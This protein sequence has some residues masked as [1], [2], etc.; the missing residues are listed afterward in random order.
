RFTGLPLATGTLPANTTSKSCVKAAD[1]DRDGD[2]DLFIGGRVIPDQYPKATSSLLLR[3]DSKPGQP[4]FTDVTAQV[5]PA[6]NNIGLVCDALWTDPDNDG[7]VD[8]ML[9]GEFMPLTL[10]TNDGGKLTNQ[11]TDRGLAKSVGWWNSLVAGD[12]DRD[13]DIDYIAGN[14]GLNARMRATNEEPVRMYAGDFDNNGFYDAIP[15]IF[16]PDADGRRQEYT[17]HGR[18]DLIKQMIVMR[19]RFPYYKDFA[20]ATIDK[21]LT[22]EERQNAT[23]LEANYLQSAYVENK[24]DGTFAIRALPVQAQLAPIFGMV[25]EDVDRDG[26]LDVV[27]VGNDFSGEVLSGRY[28]ALNGLWLRGNGKGNFTAQSIA[29]SGFYVP[30]NGKAL[31]QLTDNKGAE[32][33]VATQNRGRL[34]IFRNSKPVRGLRLSPTDATALLTFSDGKKQKV[35]FSYGNSFLSQS[36]RRLLVSPQVKSVE[37]TDSQGRKRQGFQPNTLAKK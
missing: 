26:N 33:L 14:L 12:F 35:E 27:L 7:D 16:I 20:G 23:V 25:A 2:L 30:G 32:L 28:D 5:A 6:L 10:L 21:L 1:F 11:G 8:L 31:A 22:P 13:G 9:A 19:R 37:I 17:F 3:N 34:C 18:E 29:T 4:R 15:T 24:G 36:A